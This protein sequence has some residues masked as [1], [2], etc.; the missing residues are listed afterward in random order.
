MSDIPA[1]IPRSLRRAAILNRATVNLET[2]T[3]ELAF[4]SEEPVDR[5]WGIEILGHDAGEVDLTWI[6][7]GTAPLLM[8]HDTEDQI[9]VVDSATIGADRKARAMVRFSSSPCASEVLQDVADGIRANVSVGYEVLEWQQS[10]APG[11]PPEYRATKWRPLEISLVA[12]P[13]DQTVGVGRGAEPIITTTP[14]PEPIVKEVRMADEIQAPPAPI[15]P[16][17]TAAVEA[18]RQKEILDLAALANVRDMGVDAIMAGD[19]V[20]LFRG[21]VLLARQ[22]QQRP[23]GTPP[24]AL[25]L[26][27]KETQRYSLLR[28]IRGMVDKNWDEAGFELEC[29]REV[30]KRLGR[31]AR[32]SSFFVPLE[33]QERSGAAPSQRA[34]AADFAAQGGFLVA[35]Q[36]QGFIQVL[37]NRSVAMKMGASSLT[38]IVGNITI[39]KQTAPAT[40][41][42]LGSEQTAAPTSQQTFGQLS[43][44]P[45]NVAAYTE[46]SRQL[47]LQSSPSADQLVMNDLAAVVALAVDLAAINGSGAAGQPLGIVNTTGIGSVSGALLSTIAYA[48]VINFQTLVATANALINPDAA[49]YVAA[50]GVA[51]LL[52][53]RNR[54]TNTDTPLWSD[55]LFDGKIGG[56]RGMS[57]NQM[58]SGTMLFGDWSQLIIAEWGALELELN[59]YANFPAGIQG[60]RCFYTVDA[61]VRYAASFSYGT[62]IA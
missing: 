17:V 26:T 23:L 46:V 41:Y 32:G 16:D 60:I 38:G 55:N 24:T 39:P 50:T 27:P 15:N 58:T 7:G 13:A 45:H 21:K 51:A 5:P 31:D 44:T 11:M 34:L 25:D 30:A 57:S 14:Q 54:F 19:S 37:R 3:V 40:A 18:R 52:M 2:R 35:T 12:L 10:Q 33:V 48:G 28:A 29:S 9:G 49:G 6:G 36:N 22:G 4:S 59:P 53:G 61:G 62:S 47:L 1:G 56:S 8:E 43:L 20:E 42:W